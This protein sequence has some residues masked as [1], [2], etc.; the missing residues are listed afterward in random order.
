VRRRKVAVLILIALPLP[1]NHDPFALTL[2]HH[3][4]IMATRG[5]RLASR[6]AGYNDITAG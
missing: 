6:E 5:V 2:S 4:T 1:R 3:L